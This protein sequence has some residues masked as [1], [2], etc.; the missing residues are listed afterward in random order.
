MALQK[1]ETYKGIVC[2]YHKIIKLTTGF[3]NHVPNAE[4]YSN[5]DVEVALYKDA[6]QRDHDTERY[7]RVKTYRFVGGAPKAPASE[8]IDKVY[9]A[10]KRLPEYEEAIDV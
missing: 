6:E 1:E 10:L 5:M 2:N 4:S 3:H 9:I 8:K 7:L